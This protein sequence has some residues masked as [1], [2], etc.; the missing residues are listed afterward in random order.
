MM[1]IFLL[2]RYSCDSKKPT[3][4]SLSISIEI[5][6]SQEVCQI[7]ESL[8]GGCQVMAPGWGAGGCDERNRGKGNTSQSRSQ[9]HRTARRTPGVGVS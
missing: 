7:L 2:L 6:S 3:F 1:P 4:L 8:R 5:N 9:D